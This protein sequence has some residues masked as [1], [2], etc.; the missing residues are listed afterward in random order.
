M[1][2]FRCAFDPHREEKQP[3]LNLTEL[4]LVKN[5]VD[6]QRQ[7]LDKQRKDL[8]KL[9]KAF[10]EQ[11]TAINQEKKKKKEFTKAMME[12]VNNYLQGDL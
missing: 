2:I 7:D 10:E 12:A 11:G 3:C 1:H 6:K 4:R 8:D 9:S 5:E